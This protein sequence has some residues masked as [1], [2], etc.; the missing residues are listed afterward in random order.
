MLLEATK[1]PDVKLLRT[2]RFHDARGFFTETFSRRA[3]AACGIDGD[4]VQDNHSFSGPRGVVRGLHFQ[5]PPFAQDKLV[6]VVRGAILDIAV[7]LRVGS[8]FY[9]RHVA[10]EIREED[11][12]QLY[13]PAGFAHGFCT[14]VPETEVLYKVSAYYSPQHDRGIRWNDP[15]LGIDWPIGADAAIVSDKDRA[16]PLLAETRSYFRYEPALAFSA[17]AS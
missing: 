13:I 11:S 2:R 12:T 5:I 3:L 10:Q 1:I 17:V 9:G 15:R 16:L 4:F 7:D 8:P 14:L 6:R